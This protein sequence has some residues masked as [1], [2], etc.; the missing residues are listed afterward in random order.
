[1]VRTLPESFT[2]S[3]APSPHHEVDATLEVKV[4]AT[5]QQVVVE[6]EDAAC[7]LTVDGFGPVVVVWFGV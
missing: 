1:M 2:G 5:V 7:G 6:P 4:Q 3:S